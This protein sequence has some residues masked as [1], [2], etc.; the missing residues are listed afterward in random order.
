MAACKDLLCTME[1]KVL[2]VNS[3][4]SGPPE[5]C[6]RLQQYILLNQWHVQS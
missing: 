3:S 5:T 1:L 4:V 6:L 2:D